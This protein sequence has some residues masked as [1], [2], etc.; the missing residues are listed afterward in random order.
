MAKALLLAAIDLRKAI[1][2]NPYN[3]LT[4]LC[5]L[6]RNVT[7][8]AH[9]EIKVIITRWPE[10]TGCTAYTVPAPSDYVPHDCPVDASATKLAEDAYT[11]GLPKYT[12]EYGAA[13]MRLLDFIISELEKEC[14]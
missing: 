12:G 11:Y 9:K 1:K 7:P 6:L 13:R 5:A 3:Y 14:G 8:N 4:G 2:H 10:G